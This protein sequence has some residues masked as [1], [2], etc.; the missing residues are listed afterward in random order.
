MMTVMIV[1]FQEYARKFFSLASSADEGE[2]TPELA[3]VMKKLWL[4]SGVQ[5][6][7]SRSREYQLND[8]AS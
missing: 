6:C 8:S 4:D 7:F 3:L 2:L 5:H 1:V